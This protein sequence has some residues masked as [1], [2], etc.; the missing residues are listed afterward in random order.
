MFLMTVKR[1]LIVGGGASGVLTAAHL[2]RQTRVSLAVT[3]VE[4]SREL[5][6]GIAYGTSHPDHL[7]NVRAANMS[8]FPDDPGH[9]WRWVSIR[10]GS[11]AAYSALCRRI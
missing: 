1:I 4:R 11:A 9:F 10:G 8:A 7:L 3:L 5:G 2:L 6:A